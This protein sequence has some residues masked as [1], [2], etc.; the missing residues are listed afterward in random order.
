MTQFWTKKNAQKIAFFKRKF[1]IEITQKKEKFHESMKAENDP[2]C[3]Q[4]QLSQLIIRQKYKGQFWKAE[5]TQILKLT[6]LFEFGED[7]R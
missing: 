2:W 4:L 5:N 6:L 3:L 7:L 1:F